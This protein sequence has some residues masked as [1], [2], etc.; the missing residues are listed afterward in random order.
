[1]IVLVKVGWVGRSFPGWLVFSLFFLP[2]K[3]YEA[4]S[5]QDAAVRGTDGGGKAM[6]TGVGARDLPNQKIYS[7]VLRPWQNLFGYIYIY[8]AST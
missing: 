2:T 5:T 3:N 8:A 1:M 4:L 7:S 6:H